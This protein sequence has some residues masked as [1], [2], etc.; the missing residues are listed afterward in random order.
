MDKKGIVSNPVAD[1]N[2]VFVMS[3]NG[4]VAAYSL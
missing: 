2:T 3:N 1:G 4:A